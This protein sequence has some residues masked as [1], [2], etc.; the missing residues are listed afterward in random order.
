M[1]FAILTGPILTLTFMIVQAS[2]V[3]YAHSVALGAAT[4]GAN[5]ARLYGAPPATGNAEAQR[6]LDQIGPALTDTTVTTRISGDR[7]E[8]VVTGEAQS[9][10]PW[11]T[12]H[13]R[14]TASGPIER[15]IP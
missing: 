3:W 14:Q 5:A 10:L 13:V 15:W 11:L 8:V 9:V 7:V 6:F 12:F 4:Q 2:L 1:E